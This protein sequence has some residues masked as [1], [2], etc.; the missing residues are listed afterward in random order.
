MPTRGMLCAKKKKMRGIRSADR[1][2]NIV[3]PLEHN[4]QLLLQVMPATDGAKGVRQ[5]LSV[6][7]QGMEV[8]GGADDTNGEGTGGH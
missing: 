6:E 8:L 2:S 3:L 4:P 5:K 7:T 1:F